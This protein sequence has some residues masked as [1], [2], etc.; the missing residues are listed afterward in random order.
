MFLDQTVLRTFLRGTVHG[1]VPGKLN[2][3]KDFLKNVGIH[4]TNRNPLRK[5]R[6]LDGTNINSVQLTTTN[7]ACVTALPLRAFV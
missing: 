6:K 3:F 7:E 1:R 2:T 5:L 4:T